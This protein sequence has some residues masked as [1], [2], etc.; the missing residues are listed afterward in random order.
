M[1][2]SSLLVLLVAL[3]WPAMSLA[4]RGS[5][6][7]EAATDPAADKARELFTR[8]TEELRLGNAAVARDLLRRSL[9]L[10]ARIPTRYNLGVALRRA[11]NT[12]ESIDTFEGLLREKS[13][14]KQHRASIQE[15]VDGA[16]TELATL[17]IAITGTDKALIELDAQEVAEASQDVPLVLKVDAGE[18][19][20]IARAGG[21][22]RQRVNVGPGE[23]VALVLHVMSVAERR[24]KDRKAR[25]KKRAGW[26][27]GGVG[28][29]AAAVLTAVLVSRR[30]P[31]EADLVEGFNGVDRVLLQR[32]ARR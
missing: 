7:A 12:T 20:V 9:A 2:V 10:N 6:R 16:K 30:S 24:N 3:A 4:Q 27:S 22:S 8:A 23:T 19:V 25:R 21:T 11:G 28:L 5:K 15:Q 13:L 14:S 32:G 17:E 31:G 18:H 1:R 29:A 26:A